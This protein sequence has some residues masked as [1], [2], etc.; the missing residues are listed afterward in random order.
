MAPFVHAGYLL[1]LRSDLA[2]NPY[3]LAVLVCFASAAVAPITLTGYKYAAF[4]SLI[5]FNSLVLCQYR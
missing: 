1:M 3:A 2:T 5:T 4:L